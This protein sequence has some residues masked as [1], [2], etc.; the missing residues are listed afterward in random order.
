VPT[1]GITVLRGDVARLAVTAAQAEA[2]GFHSVWTP[3][4]Y[5]RSAVVTL[6][7][8]ST[9]PPSFR[10]SPDQCD[11]LVAALVEHAAP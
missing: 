6:T 5:T 7:R 11:E 4:F 2:A 3:E 9:C 10:L 8:M 1:R